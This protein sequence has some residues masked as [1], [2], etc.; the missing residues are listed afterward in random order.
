M[1]HCKICLWLICTSH[2]E[3]QQSANSMENPL[4]IVLK[5]HYVKQSTEQSHSIYSESERRPGYMSLWKIKPYVS[6]NFG[7]KESRYQSAAPLC[8]SLWRQETNEIFYSVSCFD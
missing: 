8:V 7:P 6:N 1:Q 3:T 4:C 5:M 2:N